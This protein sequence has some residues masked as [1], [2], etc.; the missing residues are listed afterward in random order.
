MNSSVIR[1]VL[2]R[3]F[4]TAYLKEGLR[5]DGRK[6]DKPR[7]YAIQ[8]K[9]R[10]C[11]VRIGNTAVLLE[12]TEGQGIEG[13][14]DLSFLGETTGKTL[15]KVIVD[16]GNLEEAVT[17]GYQILIDKEEVLF[18][19]TFGDLFGYYVRDPTKEEEQNSTSQFTVLVSQNEVN[20][21]KTQGDPIALSDLENIVK[22]CQSCISSA[23][24]NLS[25]LKQNNQFVGK[26]FSLKN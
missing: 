19:F 8:L 23:S 15:V 2:P 9:P 4:F 24:H 26:L 6:L 16:D 1:K 17:L 25:L 7:K 12:K 5:P 10:S 21:F 22:T 11:L 14:R 3:D 18:P 20:F 13:W